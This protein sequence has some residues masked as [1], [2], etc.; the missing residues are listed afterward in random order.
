MNPTLQD[1]AFAISSTI[2]KEDA[3]INVKDFIKTYDFSSV[4][5][6]SLAQFDPKSYKRTLLY[7]DAYI[8]IYLIGWE[9][10]QGSK[11]HDHPDNGCVMRI[12]Q[13]ELSEETYIQNNELGLE[14]LSY[15]NL[16]LGECGHIKK[17][18]ILHRVMN[19]SDKKS[20]SLHI[21][22]PPNFKTKYYEMN[23]EEFKA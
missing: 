3:L 11:I 9:A 5:F 19:E 14:K 1:F 17:S 7:A 21:Y 2:A 8:D 10:K 6:P 23:G 12:L 13:N 4:D 15:R 18:T 16:K 22:S 20:L